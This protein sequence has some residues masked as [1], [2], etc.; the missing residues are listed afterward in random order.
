MGE[1]AL[2]GDELKKLIKIAKKRPLSYAAVPG[3][4]DDK[5]VFSLHRQKAPD[6]LG[7][8]LK[9]EGDG[10]KFS[11]GL[12]AVEK[13]LMTLTCEREIPNLAKKLKKFLKKQKAPYNVQIMDESG[14]LI[15]SDIEELPDDP[16]YDEEAGEGELFAAPEDNTEV[17]PRV[18]QLRSRVMKLVPVIRK[19][20][21]ELQPKL[22]AAAKKALEFINAGDFE[23]A[24]LMIGRIEQSLKQNLAQPKAPENPNAGDLKLLAQKLSKLRPLVLNA[25][26]ADQE[27]LMTAWQMV[28]SKIKA[29]DLDGATKTYTVLETALKKLATPQQEQPNE[30]TAPD[31]LEGEWKQVIARIEPITLAAIKANIGDPSKFRTVLMMAKE[32]AAGGDFKGAIDIAKRLEDGIRKAKEAPKP[33]TLNKTD[34]TKARLIWQKAIS[35][36][37]KDLKTVCDAIV[38]AVDEEQFPGIEKAVAG[39]NEYLQPLR[40]KLEDELDE[41]IKLEDLGAR[42]QQKQAC[43]KLITEYRTALSSPFFK[44]IDDGNG[45]TKVQLRANALSAL[46][47]IDQQLAQAQPET[48]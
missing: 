24:T 14:N 17:D 36:M 21:G 45:F 42:E 19:V 40:G 29:N 43:R 41:L 15:D 2:E 27:R 35:V 12:C 7:K 4:S 9:K 23:N 1:I 34:F 38:E 47:E 39:L 28:A 48:V 37:E 30:T 22:Q 5:F 8:L 6:A 33:Q 26:E 25:P 44:A 16:M 18:E 3:S 32:K 11:Y 20:G 31:P 10:N 46:D 13:K